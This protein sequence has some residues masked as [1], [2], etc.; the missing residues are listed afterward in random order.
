MLFL[1]AEGA[2]FQLGG[3]RLS[4]CHIYQYGKS[5]VVYFIKTIDK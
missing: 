4:F 3:S 1:F 2:L 5:F